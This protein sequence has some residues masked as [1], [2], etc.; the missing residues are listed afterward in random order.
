M[1]RC[2]K[3]VTLVG[4]KKY[5]RSL[6]D[7]CLLAKTASMYPRTSTAKFD[8]CITPYFHIDRMPH[9]IPGSYAGPVVAIGHGDGGGRDLQVD[10]EGWQHL[11]REGDGHTDRPPAERSC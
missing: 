1:E 3:C 5:Q 8:Y 2:K 10:V 9:W 11:G 4:T 7:E 6:Q